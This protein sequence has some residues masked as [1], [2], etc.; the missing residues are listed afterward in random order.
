[1]AINVAILGFGVVGGGTA[2]LLTENREGILA[3]SGADIY[4]KY[5]LD[6]RD[7]PDSPF[8]D[9]ITR[10]IATII[11]DP[12]VAVV[13]ETM[14]GTHPAYEY[15]RR[16]LEA[17]KS[18]V[19][20]NKQLVSEYGAELLSIAEAH[21]C[22]YLYEASTGGGIPI[23][24]PLR[25]D[26]AGNEIS[27]ISGILNGTTNYILTRMIRGGV[28][29]EGALAEAQEKGYAERNPEADVEGHDA[30]RKIAILGATAFGR[31]VPTERIHTEGITGIRLTDVMA[32]EKIG[33]SI[34][35]LGRAIC[36]G[37][38]LFMMVA[39]FLVNAE[40]PLSHIDGVYNGVLVS[41]NYVGDVMF[42]GQGAGA[43]ATAS[44]V[45][46]DVIAAAADKEHALHNQVWQEADDSCPTA[47]ESFACRN[48]IAVSCIEKNAVDVLFGE[49]E[50]IST[51]EGELAFLTDV[52]PESETADKLARL[53]SCGGQ[54]L[55]RIRVYERS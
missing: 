42:Y 14:G 17:G 50:L 52:I 12:E 15:T 54:L 55:S 49:V 51:V 6:I 38:E 32:A 7:F 1:M 53:A 30:C 37:D 20:S 2:A 13:A 11:N 35:L 26:L 22:V 4:V 46:A 41:G 19:T 8:A 5:I 10:D 27:E 33:A 45:A 25:Y 23:L 31:I 9:R 29:F 40:C 16:L 48:Y 44:A 43:K 36:R 24:R 28:S 18:V 47:F 39:P 3:R 34:K 21:G